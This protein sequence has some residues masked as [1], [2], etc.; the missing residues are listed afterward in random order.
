MGLGF[1]FFSNENNEPLHL[2]VIKGSA[3]GKI[4]LLPSIEIAY[5]NRFTNNEIKMIIETTETHSETF[6]GKWNEHFSKYQI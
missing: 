4:W 3:N 6:K 5:M 2:H 1:F